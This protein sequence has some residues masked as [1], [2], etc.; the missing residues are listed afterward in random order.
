VDLGESTDFVGFASE[1]Q[2]VLGAETGSIR[3]HDTRTGQRTTLIESPHRLLGIA[4]SRAAPAWV[5]SVWDD[6]T[7]WRKNLTTGQEATRKLTELP[8]SSLLALADGT[9][10]FAVG[11]ELRAWTPGDEVR[12]HATLPQL[13]VDLGEAGRGH[14]V[15]FS[16]SGAAFLVDTSRP[17]Q[18][19]DTEHSV[20]SRNKDE[21]AVSMS[22]DT[23]LIVI[24]QEGR[25]EVIDP[26]VRNRKWTLA[27][28][29]GV[30]Y[31]KPRISTDGRWVLARA[32]TSLLVWSIALPG[33]PTEMATW[34]ETM[35]NAVADGGAQSFGWK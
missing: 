16:V 8:N 27:S 34:L 28:T 18:V 21:Q 20:G 11:R 14:A 5:A 19:V 10:L 24:A 32:G 4:W 12:I 17:N 7:V 6:A 9:I 15:A 25:I 22:A 2:I 26:R 23:G 3:L 33:G 1:H 31:S 30:T 35:T 13:I 29:P